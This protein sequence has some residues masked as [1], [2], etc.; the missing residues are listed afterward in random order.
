[1]KNRSLIIAVSVVATFA[2]S[3][4]N[5]ISVT[6]QSAKIETRADSVAYALGN[7]I[8]NNIQK[9]FPDVNPN[10]VANAFVEAFEGK[11]NKLFENSQDAD[12]FI[13][14][15]MREENDKKAQ[16]NKEKGE[17]FLNENAKKEGVQVTESGLQYE[18]LVEGDGPKPTAENT[19]KVHYH[20][21]TIDGKVFDSSV[22]RGEPA[23]FPLKGVIKGWTEGVQ[24][25]PVGSKY[26]FYIP[27]ELAYG[28]RQQGPDIPPHS[29][30]IFE[31][32]LLEIVE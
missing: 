21:T 30:L 12:M 11:E 19:V 25:M 23:T 9:Q 17:A 4:C 26:K 32:E 5:N 14:T 8:G 31:V 13:R 22:D 7:S 18:V 10:I 16:V 20:G 15:Y 1:M 6:G 24:L 27:S 28:P 29:T 3:A 2:I